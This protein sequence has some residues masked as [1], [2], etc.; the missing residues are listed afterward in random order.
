MNSERE[1]ILVLLFLFLT[2]ILASICSIVVGIL[3]I[4]CWIIDIKSKLQNNIPA[5]FRNNSIYNT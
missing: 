3:V 2:F 1:I 4:G 5:A